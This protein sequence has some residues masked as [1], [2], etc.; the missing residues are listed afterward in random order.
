MAG[1]IIQYQ[2]E[3]GVTI[4]RLE[5]T[6]RSVCLSQADMAEL[7]LT[8]KRSISLRIRN[9]LDEGEL[10]EAATLKA[11][12]INAPNAAEQH[13]VEAIGKAKAIE[14]SQPQRGSREGERS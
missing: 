12:A 8:T 7:F 13:L 10:A 1:E 5:A 2:T 9:I 3:D 14:A 6:D 11:R 4:I